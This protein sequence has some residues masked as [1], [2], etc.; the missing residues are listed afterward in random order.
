MRLLLTFCIATECFQSILQCDQQ[1]CRMVRVVHK[2][3][4][5]S[6]FCQK[7]K[8]GDK[9]GKLSGHGTVIRT[10]E[11]QQFLVPGLGAIR[12]LGLMIKIMTQLGSPEM[13]Q[14]YW[15]TFNH[16]FFPNMKISLKAWFNVK[17]RLARFICFIRIRRRSDYGARGANRYNR[18]TVALMRNNRTVKDWV[19]NTNSGD[20]Y[21]ELSGGL[22]N[23][24]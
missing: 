14:E 7:K 1:G 15:A 8:L 20:P 24:W 21:K 4:C 9:I 5:E 3:S 12:A 13:Q 23:F 2:P 10:L 16:I 11:R 19:T 17:F 18:M 6:K 22:T